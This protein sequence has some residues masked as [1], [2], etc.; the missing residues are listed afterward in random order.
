[1]KLHLLD[2]MQMELKSVDVH[3]NER[4]TG[5]WI[6][7]YRVPIPPQSGNWTHKEMVEY[8]IGYVTHPQFEWGGRRIHRSW[9]QMCKIG[10]T[11][12]LI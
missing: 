10:D 2:G 4:M 5:T 11:E 7:P 6:C 3:F 8:A 12:I 9:I 1:M